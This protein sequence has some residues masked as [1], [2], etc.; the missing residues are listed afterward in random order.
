MRRA[1]GL[2]ARLALVCALLPVLQTPLYAQDAPPPPGGVAG[3]IRDA[4][5]GAGIRGVAVRSLDMNR[6]AVFTDP[7]GAFRL[8]DLPRGV[9]E[10]EISHIAHGTATQLVN[11]PAGTTISF[12]ATL[13]FSAV[14][15]DSLVVEVQIRVPYLAQVGFFERERRGLGSHYSGVDLERW[16]A[17]QVVRM[18]PGVQY[19]ASGTSHFQRAVILRVNGRRC[20]PPIFLDG[21][22]Q[23]WAGGNVEAVVSGVPIAAV[24]V[25]R[26]IETPPE[27]LIPAQIR[28]CG[29]VVLWRER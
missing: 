11:I 12:E 27:F 9:H 15:L 17:A 22:R 7:D 3:T 18:S 2:I 8:R 4:T 13:G 28:P 1:P 21:I 19:T 10:L 25:Y 29:A 5:S 26:G 24:E 6:P 16:T 14:A 23:M 20:T